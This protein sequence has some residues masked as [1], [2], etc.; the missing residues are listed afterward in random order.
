MFLNEAMVALA[1]LPGLC[2]A[3]GTVSWK[4]GLMPVPGEIPVT[5]G[6]D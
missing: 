2:L 3:A 1:G 4:P 6:K 5:I